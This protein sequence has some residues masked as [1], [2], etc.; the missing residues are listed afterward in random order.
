MRQAPVRTIER[1]FRAFIVLVCLSLPTVLGLPLYGGKRF[2]RSSLHY[3]QRSASALQWTPLPFAAYQ[4][5]VTRYYPPY[6]QDYSLEDYYP[7]AAY[8]YTPPA[9]E[10]ATYPYYYV[11]R[12]AGYYA[13]KDPYEEPYEE[14]PTDYEF[15][16][17]RPWFDDS[18]DLDTQNSDAISGTIVFGPAQSTARRDDTPITYGKKKLSKYDD[19]DEDVRELKS[20]I[21][22]EAKPPKKHH[23]DSDSDEQSVYIAER[24]GVFDLPRARWPK[25]SALKPLPPLSRAQPELFE[26]PHRVSDRKTPSS[27]PAPAPTLPTSTPK[28]GQKEEL[29]HRPAGSIQ[30]AAV[31]PHGSPSVIDTIKSLLSLEDSLNKGEESGKPQKRSLVTSEDALVKDLGALRKKENYFRQ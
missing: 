3:P 5:R 25:K 8:Y 28:N 7:Q 4:P 21:Y 15:A 6:S 17:R 31:R 19:E 27:V 9:A 13:Y 20:L 10:D 2:A 12:P 26:E 1:L 18:N 30:L 24:D 14:E 11:D 29:Y 16:E 23:H 22:G